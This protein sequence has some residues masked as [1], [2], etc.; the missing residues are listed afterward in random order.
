M[1]T[2]VI[3]GSPISISFSVSGYPSVLTDRISWSFNSSENYNRVE[4][5]QATDDRYTFSADQL[6]LTIDASTLQD[7]G[8]YTVMA[9]NPVGTGSSSITLRVG[10]EPLINKHT[11]PLFNA[12]CF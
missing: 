11:L 7:D 9:S 3:S 10:G 1:E 2:S 8:V 6:T 4:I 12:Y 5:T